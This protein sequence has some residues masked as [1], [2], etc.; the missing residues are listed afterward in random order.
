MQNCCQVRQ[1]WVTNYGKFSRTNDSAL[2]QILSY[3][4]SQAAATAPP[5]KARTNVASSKHL[6]RG[7]LLGWEE[8]GGGFVRR[9]GRPQREGRIND[10]ERKRGQCRRSRRCRRSE[11]PLR[12]FSSQISCMRGSI[13]I[14]PPPS[15]RSLARSV[16]ERRMLKTKTMVMMAAAR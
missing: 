14:G 5:H 6:V 13:E 15:R 11:R 4:P 8:R 16:G 9:D 10:G 3:H 7:F 2:I 12:S 1:G